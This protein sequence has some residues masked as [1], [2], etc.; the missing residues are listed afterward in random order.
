MSD[1]D[2]KKSRSDRVK[3]DLKLSVLTGPLTFIVPVLSYL[4]LYPIILSRSS[5]EVL[6]IWS[7]YVTTV[8]FFTVADIGFSQHLI[9]EAGAD[10]EEEVLI[11]LKKELVSAKRFYLLLGVCGIA[12]IFLLKNSLFGSSENV[13]SSSALYYSAL[14]LVI[15][16]TLQLV[17]SLDAA[18]LSARADNYFI[19]L[20]RAVS[21]VFTYGVA[22][23]GAILYSPI[24]GF[25]TGFLLANIFLLFVYYKRIKKKHTTWS[26]INVSLTLKETSARLKELFKQGW[27]LYSVS[28]GM[29]L[30]QPVI[31]YVIAIIMGLPAVGV[32]DIAIRV[33]TTSR[34]LITSGFASLYPSLSYYYR[35]K[36]R[37]KLIE[38]ITIS[39]ILLIPVGAV[40]LVILV[41]FPELIYSKWLGDFPDGIISATIILAVWQFIT[42]MNVPFWY[43][44]QASHNEKIAAIA[45]WVHTVSIL[46]L[47]LLVFTRINISLDQ[48]LIYWTITALLTQILI[49]FFAESKLSMFWIVLKSR[50]LKIVFFTSILFFVANLLAGLVI[51]FKIEELLIPALVITTLFVLSLLPLYVPILK[52]SFALKNVNPGD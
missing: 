44:L 48:L 37:D 51:S 38:I 13:Y 18:V 34:D 21:P 42:I 29:I 5:L 9:R 28:L 16:T 30:R 10:R 49:Y 3:R 17:S 36:E 25:A 26:K 47:L 52:K 24:E 41:F 22:I 11:K 15:G 43:L 39:L 23:I 1:A 31:R 14:I 4:F 50:R 12:I 6:G 46:L 33:T 40:S 2:E 19:K 27:Q 7:L 32:F 35:N 45:I 20:V 8:S